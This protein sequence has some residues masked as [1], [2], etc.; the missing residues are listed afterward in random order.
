V[1]NLDRTS[2][3]GGALF[4][5]PLF[6]VQRREGWHS[7]QIW[8]LDADMPGPV[9][10]ERVGYDKE[11]PRFSSYIY[12]SPR[13]VESDDWGGNDLS[14]KYGHCRR[15]AEQ[16]G[17][18]GKLISNSGQS[19]FGEDYCHYKALDFK[20]RAE[21]AR[22]FRWVDFLLDKIADVKVFANDGSGRVWLR[23]IILLVSSVPASSVGVAGLIS[24]RVASVVVLAIAATL[25]F[26]WGVWRYKEYRKGKPAARDQLDYERDP[27]AAELSDIGV[28]YTKSSVAVADIAIAFIAMLG[29][30]MALKLAFEFAAGVKFPLPWAVLPTLLLSLLFRP[31]NAAFTVIGERAIFK[32]AF[33]YGV[34]P[35]R[36][37]LTGLLVVISF[38]TLFIGSSWWFGSVVGEVHFKD[39]IGN[40][41][42][43]GRDIGVVESVNAGIYLSAVTFTTLGYGDFLPTGFL[44]WIA[45]LEAFTGALVMA[46]MVVVLARKFLRM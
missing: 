2:V 33:G 17:T 35:S 44:R 21:I 8:K 26:A 22:Y 14:G 41:A 11:S 24:S 46:M 1:A 45:G 30:A 4:A 15:V 23:A 10:E 13:L 31:I 32:Y 28:S 9:F 12:N 25:V 18:L 43:I 38:G 5:S 29:F 34:S 6:L 36:V 37:A 39:R 19:H 40:A 7:F 3:L 27:G 16:Y 42:T 20:G